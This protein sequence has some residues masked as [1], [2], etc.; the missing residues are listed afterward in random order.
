M[1]IKY[2]GSL[3]FGSLRFFDNI[4]LRRVPLTDYIVRS[5]NWKKIGGVKKYT[6]EIILDE[7][8]GYKL[9]SQNNFKRIDVYKKI[10]VL[11]LIR[12]GWIYLRRERKNDNGKTTKDG[13]HDKM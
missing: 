7:S 9:L 2:I 12:L 6:I 4:V 5:C 3:S 1:K 11:D 13:F 10:G 8:P